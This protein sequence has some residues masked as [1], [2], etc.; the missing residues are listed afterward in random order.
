MDENIDNNIFLKY[1]NS[2]GG[3]RAIFNSPYFR[4]SIIL[5]IIL[6]PHWIKPGWW[7][8][9]LSVMPSVLG[10]SLGGFAMWMSVG[11]NDFKSII[12]GKDDEDSVSPFMEVN[13]TFAHFILLQLLSIVLAII[14]K[15]YDIKISTQSVSYNLLGD[16]LFYFDFLLY[17]VSYFIF[18][19]ALLTA[20]AAVMALFRVS[21]WYDDMQTKIHLEKKIKTNFITSI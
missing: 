15:A 21:S 1:W 7:E 19:Y 13:A 10:F 6:F 20:F 3:F 11:D 14:S 4:V 18:I 9:V 2:Y 12:A 17:C 8:T 16:F 5:T